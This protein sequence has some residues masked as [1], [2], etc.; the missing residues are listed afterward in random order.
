M[1]RYNTRLLPKHLACLEQDE[2]GHTRNAVG[3]G[4]FRVFINV[5]LD[6]ACFITDFTFYIREDGCH[7]FAR[8]APGGEKIDQHRLVGIDQF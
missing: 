1:R 5:D 3:I 2:G 6:D 8:A 4:G 7:R